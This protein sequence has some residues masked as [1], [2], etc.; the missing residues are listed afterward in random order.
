MSKFVD[1]FIFA[2]YFVHDIE[3]RLIF[4]VDISNRVKQH[5]AMTTHHARKPRLLRSKVS[6]NTQQID[7]NWLI[8]EINLI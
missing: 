1:I 3:V 4:G 8:L 2:F 5:I 6:N 7:R